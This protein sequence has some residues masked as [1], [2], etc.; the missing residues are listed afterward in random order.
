MA[1]QQPAK[2]VIQ[3]SDS[4]GDETSDGLPTP[5]HHDDVPKPAP[6]PQPMVPGGA[7]SGI[8]LI[9]LAAMERTEWSKAWDMLG[10]RIDARTQ[11]TSTTPQPAPRAVVR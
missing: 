11:L 4:S 2:Q 10:I 9:V 3:V 1:R 8:S 7:M 5:E 6:R